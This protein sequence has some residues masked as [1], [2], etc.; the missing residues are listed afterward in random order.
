MEYNGGIIK[1]WLKSHY[2]K[3]ATNKKVANMSHITKTKLWKKNA[4]TIYNIC[5]C[6]ET[7][8]DGNMENMKPLIFSIYKYD[9]LANYREWRKDKGEER[10]TADKV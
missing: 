10:R 8:N 5:G 7:S 6:D 4:S 3:L 1:L 2:V 9:S